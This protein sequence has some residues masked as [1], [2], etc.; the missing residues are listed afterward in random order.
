MSTPNVVNSIVR[1]L[2][3]LN[4]FSSEDIAIKNGKKNRYIMIK[5]N[6]V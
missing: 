3:S 6:K 2:N 1:K 5:K 4:L